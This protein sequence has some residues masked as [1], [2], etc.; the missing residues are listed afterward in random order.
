MKVKLCALL[1]TPLTK[2]EEPPKTNLAALLLKKAG[3]WDEDEH[4]RDEEGQFTTK[5]NGNVLKDGQYVDQ[6]TGKPLPKKDQ[7]RLAALKVPKAWT[8]V[9]LNP[10]EEGALQVVG[11]DAKGRAQYLYSA[12]HSEA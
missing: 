3:D 2:S 5:G 1:R 7:E 6:V 4:P 11:R 9:R 12:A 10:D 8:D